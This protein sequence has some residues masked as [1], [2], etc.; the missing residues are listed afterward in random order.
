MRK[1]IVA[2][3]QVATNIV[4][5]NFLMGEGSLC[6]VLISK[7]VHVLIKTRRGGPSPLVLPFCVLPL[8]VLPPVNT[9]VRETPYSLHTPACVPPV[10]HSTRAALPLAQLLLPLV[11]AAHPRTSRR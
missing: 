11:A 1:I 8:P 5:E 9:T 10:V 4:Y 6:H 7:F 3:L 2:S